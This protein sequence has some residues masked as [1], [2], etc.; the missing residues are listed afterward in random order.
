MGIHR[1]KR[2]TPDGP[3]DDLNSTEVLTMY[4]IEYEGLTMENLGVAMVALLSA[5]PDD[6]LWSKPMIYAHDDTGVIHMEG[7]R[8]KV[9]EGSNV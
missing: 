5:I 2:V 7:I 8:R 4:A 6:R 3:V 9:F 1:P